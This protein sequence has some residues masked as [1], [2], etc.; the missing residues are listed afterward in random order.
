MMKSKNDPLRPV[1]K[2]WILFL[3]AVTGRIFRLRV[4]CNS[5]RKQAAKDMS[6]LFIN[7]LPTS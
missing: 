3:I 6:Q 4:H 2:Q 1:F 5:Y 7:F